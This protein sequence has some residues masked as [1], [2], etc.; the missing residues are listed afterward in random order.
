MRIVRE[1]PAP[2]SYS[3]NSA[4]VLS[5]PMSSPIYR[6]TAQTMFGMEDL[7]VAELEGIGALDNEQR[8]ALQVIGRNVQRLGTLIEEMIRLDIRPRVTGKVERLENVF[9]NGFSKVEVTLDPVSGFAGLR[10]GEE[11]TFLPPSLIGSA[12]PLD[13]ELDVQPSNELCTL[14]QERIGSPQG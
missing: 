8:N 4:H 9:I 7:L 3:P 14:L 2:G 1:Y 12:S 10:V 5:S 13:G 11:F 6:M